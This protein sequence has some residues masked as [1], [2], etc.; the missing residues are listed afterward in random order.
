[1]VKR[2][3]YTINATDIS[4]NTYCTAYI[5]ENRKGNK[6][7]FLFY[8]P[9]FATS[10]VDKR[11]Y[12]K[13]RFQAVAGVSSRVMTELSDGSVGFE[14]NWKEL[15]EGSTNCNHGFSLF[16]DIVTK[17]DVIWM[18]FFSADPEME[19]GYIRPTTNYKLVIEQARSETLETGS[20]RDAEEWFKC[21][22]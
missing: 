17:G 12:A 5:I 8:D 13:E 2:Y 19:S 21:L 18:H 20:Y 10:Y 3:G 7:G 1:M 14:T 15:S 4:I 6:F 16:S 11:I 9:M 22:S